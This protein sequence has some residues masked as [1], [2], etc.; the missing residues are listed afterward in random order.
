MRSAVIG[1]PADT[2]QVGE[3]SRVP[4]PSEARVG[5]FRRREATP[6]AILNVDRFHKAAGEQELPRQLFR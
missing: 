1:R 6:I 4:P 5:V 2:K 3:P